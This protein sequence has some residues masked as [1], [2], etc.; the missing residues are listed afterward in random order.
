MDQLPLL[1]GETGGTGGRVLAFPSAR[2]M[3]ALAD[4]PLSQVEYGHRTPQL[5]LQRY[6]PKSFSDLSLA[7]VKQVLRR[8]RKE[9]R[10]EDLSD[11]WATMMEDAHLDSVWQTFVAPIVAARWELAPAD[12]SEDLTVAAEI[13][14]DGC[15]EALKRID[16]GDTISALLDDGEGLGY[17][18]AEIEWGTGRLLGRPAVVPQKLTPILARRFAWSDDFELGLYDDGLAVGELKKAGH[19]VDVIRGRGVQMA[20]LPAGKYIVHQP[21]R[22]HAVP[23]GRGVIF[24]VAKWWWIK[25][26]VAQAALQGAEA[27]ANPRFIAS[28][29][30]ATPGDSVVD[31]LLD[32][33]EK[34]A[35]DG[36]AVLRGKTRIDVIDSKGEGASRTWEMYLKFADAAMSKG[37]L[38]STLNVEVGDSGGNRSLGE[39]Q[40]DQTIGPRRDQAAAN[41]WLSLR[42]DLL[43]Y[44]IKYNP[45]IFRPGSPV[46]TGRQILSE[47]PVEIDQVIVDAKAVSYDEMR[48]SRGLTPWGGDR[49]DAI[50]QPL[51][52]TLDLQPELTPAPSEAPADVT[53]PAAPGVPG[54]VPEGL[55]VAPAED[56]QAAALNGAQVTALLEI[57]GKVTDG[58]LPRQTAI[59][60]IISAFPI[61]RTQADS[62]LGEVGKTFVKTPEGEDV[63]PEAPAAEVAASDGPFALREAAIAAALS[64]A[65]TS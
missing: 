63:P 2:E 60:I 6:S 21:M 58:L 7:D 40:A 26:M 32:G 22:F 17:G 8:A 64:R 34:F 39:S 55:D 24:A 41:I 18:A 65:L 30:Q 23:T 50:I 3:R 47:D 1:D 15:E 31:D 36:V 10:T 59:E 52:Q 35:S 46:P 49:G 61:S 53:A 14:S 38:G 29:E 27:F 62:I 16:L 19:D 37:V 54:N 5:G 48:T 51:E 42:R 11:L 28:V 12:V 43:S 9:G 13:A 33:L 44:V 25:Q 4:G 56:V 20:R 45:H 57:V